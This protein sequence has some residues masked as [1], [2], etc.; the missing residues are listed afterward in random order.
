MNKNKQMKQIKK[1]RCWIKDTKFRIVIIKSLVTCHCEESLRLSLRGVQRRSNLVFINS[2]IYNVSASLSYFIFSVNHPLF[3][4]SFSLNLDPVNDN[5]LRFI[6]YCIKNTII[7]ETN[8]ITLFFCKF[9]RTVWSWIQSKGE[10]LFVNS[11]T[12]FY[13]NRL[14]LFLRLPLYYDPVNQPLSHVL[15]NL[16]YGIKDF[17]FLS[18]FKRSLASSR[19]SINSRIFSYSFKLRTTAFLLPFLLIIYSGLTSSIILCIFTSNKYFLFHILKI[20]QTGDVKQDAGYWMNQLRNTKYGM[21]N[22]KRCWILDT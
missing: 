2:W 12:I 1:T 10:Y 5:C 16:S 19:S 13:R 7:T 8:A 21:R 6:I 11:R 15:R 4:G 3:V 22:A 18:A 17:A 20:A 9:L 14:R